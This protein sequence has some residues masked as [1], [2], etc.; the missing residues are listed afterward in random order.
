MTLSQL[1]RRIDTLKRKFARELAVIKLRRIADTVADDWDPEC[2]PEPADVI[3]RIADAGFRLPTF[4]RLS[5]YLKDARRQGEVLDP[6]SI[7]L[8]LLPWA[9]NYRYRELLRWEL[10]A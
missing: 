5:R 10:S 6:E 2:P 8:E 7:V 4:T 3:R 9:D 1:R